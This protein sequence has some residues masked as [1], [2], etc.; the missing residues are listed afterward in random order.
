MDEPYES[1]VWEL[2]TQVVAALVERRTDEGD[3]LVRA[4]A[5]LALTAQQSGRRLS[6]WL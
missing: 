4:M 3:E 2:P 1:H 5:D 6:C